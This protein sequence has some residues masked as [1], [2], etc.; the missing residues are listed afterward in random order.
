MHVKP[1]RRVRDG[2][3]A[4]HFVNPYQIHADAIQAVQNELGDECPMIV[5]QTKNLKILPGSAHQTKD[6]QEGGFQFNSDFTF[7][8][9]VCT[10]IAAN[11]TPS[12][13]DA[14]SA[15]LTLLQREIGYLGGRYK[16]SAA[17]ITAGG[18]FLQVEADSLNI[19]P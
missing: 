2:A 12:V 3:A 19:R 18:L 6:L 10:L 8:I 5:F 9:L 1:P 4:F 17:S 15:K 11:L 16:V 14:E 7:T 13:T